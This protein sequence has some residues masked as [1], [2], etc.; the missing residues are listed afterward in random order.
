MDEIDNIRKIINK[1]EDRIKELETEN[2][3]LRLSIK[4][5]CS[6]LMR[7]NDDAEEAIKESEKIL[8]FAPTFKQ[9]KWKT[10]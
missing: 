4:Q 10:K 2:R 3:A 9:P 8:A 5:A 1:L 7:Q 6:S